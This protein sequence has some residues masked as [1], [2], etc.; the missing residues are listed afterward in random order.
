MIIVADQR[1]QTAAGFSFA[2]GTCIDVVSAVAKQGASRVL[3][4]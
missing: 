4:S 2:A 1:T 3:L